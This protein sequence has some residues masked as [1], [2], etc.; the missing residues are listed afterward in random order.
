VVRVSIAASTWNPNPGE[1][2]LVQRASAHPAVS[3]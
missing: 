1:S 3:R 2:E